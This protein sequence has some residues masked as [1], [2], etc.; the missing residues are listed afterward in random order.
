MTLVIWR[1]PHP[2]RGIVAFLVVFLAGAMLGGFGMG[3]PELVA[4]ALLATVAFVLAST[5]TSRDPGTSA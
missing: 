4:L 3:V 5:R 2:I 1:L